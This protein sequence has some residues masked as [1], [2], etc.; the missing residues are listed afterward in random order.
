MAEF[1]SSA[2]VAELDAAARSSATVSARA[3]ELTLTVQQIVPDAPSGEARYYVKFDRTGARLSPG[4]ADSPDMT[5][6]VDY[7]M[8]R[9][10]SAGT[11]N[12]QDALAA[13]RL[14]IKGQVGLLLGREDAFGALDDAFASVRGATTYPEEPVDRA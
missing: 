7:A 10:L 9:E 8:A 3:D 14:K 11:A 1:L 6:I 4:S 13:G 12:A 5:L 2:W